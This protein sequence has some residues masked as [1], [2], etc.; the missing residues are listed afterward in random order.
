MT[1][2]PILL[3]TPPE[4]EIG[5][6]LGRAAAALLPSKPG[7]RAVILA[8]HA[9]HHPP[10][11]PVG[12]V[13]EA[14][15]HV[16]SD[17]EAAD[18]ERR[19]AL[20][21]AAGEPLTAAGWE[22]E[23]R[24][25]RSPQPPWRVALAVAEE[26]E[27]EVIVVGAGQH[28]FPRS[29]AL[30]RETRALAHKTTHPLLVIGNDEP[31]PSGPVLIAFDGSPPSEA[32]LETGTAILGNREYVV[33]TAWQP[34]GTTAAIAA[35]GMPGGVAAAGSEKLDDAAR[36]AATATATA[37]A[38]RIEQIGAPATPVA[39]EGVSGPWPALVTSAREHDAAAIV[40]GTRGHSR[41]TATLIGSVAEALL[42]HAG[43][44]V[45]LIPAGDT[46]G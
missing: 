7:R 45:L 24:V 15:L 34:L 3:C 39:I 18:M 28:R 40:T 5:K 10:L 12:A 31:A 17:F 13:A 2:A 32:A 11:N 6:S 33:S 38:T 20:A 16:A 14:L 21:E 42:R 9:P 43:R 30:G 37:G 1:E 22:V 19:K 41:L 26:I 23:I 35:A 44:P 8:V 46:K 29:G 4:P 25:E 27:P 36:D